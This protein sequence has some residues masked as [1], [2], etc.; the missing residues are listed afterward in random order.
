MGVSWN[1]PHLRSGWIHPD[2]VGLGSIQLGASKAGPAKTLQLNVFL[3][4]ERKKNFFFQK[5]NR[6]FC[7]ELLVGF[8]T[9]LAFFWEGGGKRKKNNTTISP[10][11][12]PT[13]PWNPPHLCCSFYPSSDRVES[14]SRSWRNS[15]ACSCSATSR[16][17]SA[18]A[19][20]CWRSGVRWRAGYLVG[21][22]RWLRRNLQG[23]PNKNQS[24]YDVVK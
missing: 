18:K 16:K 1:K 13:P 9:F 12:A 19:S 5:T 3:A 23:G 20:W 10:F 21:V 4:W 7:F 2:P 8:I 24:C 17:D 22:R 15:C 11:K 6:F 14:H